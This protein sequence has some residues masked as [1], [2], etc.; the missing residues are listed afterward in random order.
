MI[1][2]L[3]TLPCQFSVKVQ[4]TV[5]PCIDAF[6]QTHTCKIVF[7]S[8]INVNEKIANTKFLTSK[9]IF[10]NLAVFSG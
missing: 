5:I 10:L 6:I 8:G 4:E 3:S 1:Q 9:I 2:F 7:L